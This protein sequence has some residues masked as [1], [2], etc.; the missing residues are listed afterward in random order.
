MPIL[1]FKLNESLNATNDKTRNRTNNIV[2]L[3][4][5]V[6]IRDS[7]ILIKY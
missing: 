5:V 3:S 7:F 4:Y 2:D 6:P 1:L